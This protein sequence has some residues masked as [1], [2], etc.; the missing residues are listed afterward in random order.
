M[1]RLLFVILIMLGMLIGCSNNNSNES[2]KETKTFTY[3]GEQESWKATMIAKKSKQM[4]QVDYTMNIEYK[5]DKEDLKD[6]NTINY[7]Y[8]IGMTEFSRSEKRDEGFKNDR[9][10]VYKDIGEID[11]NFN[12]Q[13]TIPFKINWN[14]KE[15][16]FELKINN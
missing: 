2:D 10:V 7:S 5:G 12:E 14:D 4:S 13:T 3:S 11:F 15:L 6:I 16:E 9:A 1:K 8:Q